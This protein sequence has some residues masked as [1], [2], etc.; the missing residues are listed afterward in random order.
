M[1]VIASCR[2]CGEYLGSYDKDA[3]SPDDIELVRE[4]VTCS[5]GHYEKSLEI[6]ENPVDD[7][8]PPVE[9]PPAEEPPAE[10]P[11]P[12]WHLW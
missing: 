9:P 4:Y 8:P 7:S 3:P 2:E 10:E 6:I 11:K 5:N 12:W 1:R